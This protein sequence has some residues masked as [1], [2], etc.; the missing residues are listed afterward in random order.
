MYEDEK[1]CGAKQGHI[2]NLESTSAGEQGNYQG[3]ETQENGDLARLSATAQ[4]IPAGHCPGPTG[5]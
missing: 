2:N 3:R 4:G 5:A 1:G